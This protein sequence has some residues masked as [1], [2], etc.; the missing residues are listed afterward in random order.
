M[1][2]LQQLEEESRCQAYTDIPWWLSVSMPLSHRNYLY[3]PWSIPINCLLKDLWIVAKS[4]VCPSV[5]MKF[6]NWSLH[7][8]KGIKGSTNLE[9]QGWATLRSWRTTCFFLLLSK[10][11]SGSSFKW[12]RCQ[13]HTD[14]YN[15]FPKEKALKKR[16][17]MEY[18]CAAWIQLWN[19]LGSTVLCQSCAEVGKGLETVGLWA[20]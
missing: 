12:R 20:F 5:Y 3:E 11:S 7:P 6:L 10:S 1:L 4:A 19:V 2:A 17:S 18:H 15:I 14:T 16:Q 9:K 8:L 13:M